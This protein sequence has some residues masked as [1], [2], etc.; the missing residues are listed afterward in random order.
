[1]LRG[2]LFLHRWLGVLVG[3]LM[4]IWCLSGF[5]MMY[6]DYPRLS[7]E[8][9]VRGLAPLQWQRI[10][11]TDALD[12]PGDTKFMSARIEMVAGRPV[13]RIMP[14]MSAAGPSP[15]MKA[16]P[17]PSICRPAVRFKA[18]ARAISPR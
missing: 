4:T 18:R 8:E 2:V 16:L 5:V 15:Q 3:L 14:G 6:V 12:I 1:M 9:Q 13:L 17:R 10:A 7:T 11:A